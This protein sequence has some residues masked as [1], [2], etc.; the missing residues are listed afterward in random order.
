MHIIKK[1]SNRRLYDSQTSSYINL[2]GL[3][4]LIQQGE[5]LKIIDASSGKDISSKVLLQAVMESP[6][7][8]DVFS[9][10]FLHRLLRLSRP[11]PLQA[12]YLRQVV[13]GIAMLDSKLAQLE[14]FPGWSQESSEA[15]TVGEAKD[16]TVKEEIKQAQALPSKEIEEERKEPLE[17]I[18]I[19]EE[20]ESLPE[21]IP[22]VQEDTAAD[23]LAE[24]PSP[25]VDALRE[26]LAA[27]QARVRKN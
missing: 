2:A 10:D 18:E 6:D 17:A 20:A 21:E 7:A 14:R 26:R 24:E 25:E 8:A 23:S 16:E 5:E 13:A 9:I 19:R 4:A 3:T 27:L 15:E 12:F 1:Y 11:D 22:L